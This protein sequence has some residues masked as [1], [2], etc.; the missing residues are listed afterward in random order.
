VAVAAFLAAW[1]V[2]CQPA[3]AQDTP[4]LVQRVDVIGITPLG[5]D[6]V[7]LSKTSTNVQTLKA[8][9]ISEQGATQLAD[10]LNDNIGSVSVSNGTGSP[11]QNDVN[12]RG[13]QATSLLGAPVGL[14]VYFDGVSLNEP[15]GAL[16]NW[17]LIPMNAIARVSLIP[18]SNPVF[19]L[20]TLGGSIVLNSKN[21]R[22]QPGTSV[23]L[24]IGSFKRRALSFEQGGMANDQTDYFV[25]GNLDQEDGYR[26]HSG[27][28][29]RQLFAK[30]RWRGAGIRNTDVQLS[31]ALADTRLHGTQALPQDM[32]GDP[33]SAYTWPDKTFNKMGLLSLNASHWVGER[34][35]LVANAH[36]R[37]VHSQILNSNAA[38]DEGCYAPDGMLATTD[39]GDLA[40]GKQAP[41]GTAVNSITSADALAL[42][43][44]H[45]TGSINTSLIESS[46]RQR[47]A[48]TSLQWLNFDK[49]LDKENTLTLG[50]SLGYSRVNYSQD[51][52]LARLIDGEAVAGPNQAYGF[53]ADGL[54]PSP[55]NLPSFS[56]SPVQSQVRLQ[57]TTRSIS[58][59]FTDRIELSDK[60]SLTG[61]G[62]FNRTL[63]EQ[64]GG[65]SQ[66]LAA[67]G[68]Y[69]WVDPATGIAAYNPGYVSAYTFSNAD[70]APNPNGIPEG[71]V[72]GPVS[73]S[74]AGSHRYQRFNPALGFTYNVDRTLGL[75]G[76]YSESMR[77]PT[78]I[79]LSCADPNHPCALPTGFNGDPDL[80]PVIA[81]TVELGGRGDWGDR[82]SWN[83]AVY[84]TRLKDDI[85]FI[86][87]SSAFGYFAN[88]GE[89]ERRGWEAGIQ[90]Q[91][92]RLRLAV[93]LGHLN[94]RYKAAFT[95]AAGD[96][97]AA[98]STIPGIPS[99][100]LKVRAVYRATPQWLIGGNLVAV[101]SQIAH[102]NENNSVANGVVPG[103]ALAHLDVHYRA[104]QNL[105]W[106]VRVKN[107]FDRAYTTYG[108][109]GVTSIYSLSPQLF[110]TPAPARTLWLGLTYSLGS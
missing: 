48:G 64:A 6:G 106:T 102:G 13:F 1:A 108:L 95:T 8:R 104:T 76:N 90:A 56:G 22:D 40:C 44:G 60:F 98:G 47:T 24:G 25:A 72:A 100:T 14:S 23:T 3:W 15:F 31:M 38:L 110:S 85:Q 57:S 32:M 87:T 34:N 52:L 88:V 41:G 65:H 26:R 54:A 59:F 10:L 46:I 81:R 55:T 83:V 16:V 77:A 70:S 78:S 92:D 74:L 107:V 19:G 86:A 99:D 39:A 21:G 80:H 29:V 49:V 84:D 4:G 42:G 17:D 58:L 30:V 12:Y 33:T 53:T 61:A 37:D 2:S 45:W 101:S 5:A 28:E 43:F 66:F 20:N 18:G 51:T 82:A 7:P 79:E 11:Y 50:A 9:D 96:D 36:V 71:A 91:F 103:Y 63:I 89:T 62:S 27:S 68:G 93:N 67:D 35:K 109:S 69:A 94:A 75:F 105:E 73:N 97:V